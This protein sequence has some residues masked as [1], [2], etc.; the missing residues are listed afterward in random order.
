MSGIEVQSVRFGVATTRTQ[1]WRCGSPTR[2][3]QLILPSGH[4]EAFEDDT[5]LTVPDSAALGHVEWLDQ[6]TREHIRSIA[7]WWREMSYATAGAT[8][9]GN[10]CEGG[11][12]L[13]GDHYLASEPGGA[14]WPE[15]EADVARI[16]LEWIDMP[17]AGRCGT[18]SIGVNWLDP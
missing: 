14:F 3:A 1:C 16:S 7:P 17:L 10:A 9:L 2:V 6:G 13:Q 4:R 8:Y 18:K 15:S 5:W 12:A 11:G